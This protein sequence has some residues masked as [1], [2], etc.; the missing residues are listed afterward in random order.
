MAEKIERMELDSDS[1]DKV[2]FYIRLHSLE[3]ISRFLIF[4]VL[5]CTSL[6]QLMELQELY[7]AEQLLTSELSNKLASTEVSNE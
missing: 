7:N 3:N 4:Y 6:Q 2:H 5:P 1:K